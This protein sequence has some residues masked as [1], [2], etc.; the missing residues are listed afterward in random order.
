MHEFYSFLFRFE[1]FLGTSAGQTPE[2][3]G[4]ESSVG[5]GRAL[6]AGVDSGGSVWRYS[7]P[8]QNGWVS[9]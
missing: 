1:G 6:G 5:A 3:A 4:V 9:L 8:P 7:T 2:A